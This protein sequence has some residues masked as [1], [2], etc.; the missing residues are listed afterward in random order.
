LFFYLPV[1]RTGAFDDKKALT[2]TIS[3]RRNPPRR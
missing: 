2:K 1:R 3:I